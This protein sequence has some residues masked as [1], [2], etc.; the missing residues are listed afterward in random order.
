[1]KDF[2]VENLVVLEAS[3]GKQTGQDTK[4]IVI[5]K[6]FPLLRQHFNVIIV[7][8][9][10]HVKENTIS[11]VMKSYVVNLLTSLIRISVICA[12]KSFLLY[13]T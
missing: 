5:K 9:V 4:R 3:H 10:F 8:V 2:I 6:L 13:L 11:N 7:G 1:M 12:R